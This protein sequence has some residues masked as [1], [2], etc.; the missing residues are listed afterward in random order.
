MKGSLGKW[1]VIDIET[2]GIDPA[3][4]QI[5]DIGFLQFDGHRLVRKYSSLVKTDIKLSQFIQKLTGIKQTQVERAPSWT[6]IEPE[7][8]DLEGHYLLAHNASFEESF[9]AKYFS[10]LGSDREMEYYQDSLYFLALIFPERSSLNLEGILIDLGLADKEEH[11]GLSDSIDL[12]KVILLS[13]FLVKK[14]SEFLSY[15]RHVLSDFSKEEFWLANFLQLDESELIS[16]A[17]SIDF[18]LYFAYEHYNQ[19]KKQQF[20]DDNDKG[21]PKNLEFSGKNIKSILQD[22]DELQHILPGYQYRKSQ[23]MLSLRVGQAFLNGIHALIQAPTGTGKTMG[24]LL[25]SVLLAKSKKEQVMISTGTKALQNQAMTKDIPMMYKVLGLEHSDLSVVRLVGS[26]NHY[27]ELLYRNEMIAQ[28]NALDL[29]SF[30]ERFTHAYFDTLFFYNQ[31]IESYSDIITTDS[32]PFVFKRK[33]DKFSELEKDFRV[34]YRACTGHK[35]PYKDKCTYIQGMRLAKE[36]DI[37]VGNHSLLLSWPR[38]LER[39]QF[40]VIDEAH[41]IENEST[42]AFTQ[43]VSKHDL[44]N[45]S[46][47]MG[48]MVAPV[49]YL[50]DGP[51][52][53]EL[54]K[55]IRKEIQSSAQ[56]IQENILVLEQSIE[57]FAKNLPRYTDIYWNEFP[58]IVQGM[59]NSS[60]EVSIYNHIDSL[61]YIF[62]GV[63]DLISPLLE[64]WN[65]N[66]LED[67]NE[68]TAFTLFE[69]FVGHIEDVTETLTNLLDDTENRAGSIKYHEEHGYLLTSAPINVGEIFYEKV[70]KDSHSVVFTSATLANHDGSKGMAQ[71]EWMTGYNMIPAEKRFKT[72]LFLDNN[73][74]YENQ[75]KVFLVTDTPSLY[76][77]TF[78]DR[79]MEKIVPLIEELGGR[80]LLLFS[81]KTRFEKAC[82]I[83][84][85]TFE[86]RIPLFIQGLGQNVVE[87][88]KKSENGILIGMES[89]GEGIDIPGETLEFVYVDKVPDLRQDIV[90]QKRRDFYD[91]QFGNE[92]ADYF[93]AHRTRSLHQKLGRLLRR[94][95]DR[96]CIIVTDSRLA[97]WKPRTLD[98]FKEMMKPYRLEV[99]SFEEACHQSRDFLIGPA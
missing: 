68:I 52:E 3:Y 79:S 92:F 78:V 40:I 19:I 32:I 6:K 1:A 45:L 43:E 30:D 80:S 7:L 33:L 20:L 17:D 66:S 39:P 13:V 95:T 12:L 21:S 58:M 42:Q 28:D 37:I 86:G 35:C 75:A 61:R 15:L 4:D 71:V 59:M 5:I 48:Q 29:R 55:R 81:A 49:Y 67:E 44:D 64:K 60:V 53:E 54:A 2:T 46:K 50:L 25:P 85:K 96:G 99:C 38:S 16:I 31:R 14:D 73:Y 41:K 69:S 98:T 22:E 10:N 63:L 72:G 65:L 97:K 9:L 57:R 83:L 24:Y 90:I 94:D 51:K 89:F 77:K 8:L 62:K 47:N 76:D 88:F 70:M 26:K 82:E 34:D 11:R 23:E 84:L 18:D 91:A 27:C 93:L 87:E 36:A 56:I 74:D